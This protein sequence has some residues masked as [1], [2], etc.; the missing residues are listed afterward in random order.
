MYN[1]RIPKVI[2]NG[3]V[4]N[5]DAQS[6]A[7]VQYRNENNLIKLTDLPKRLDEVRID[8]DPIIKN[9][10][11]LSDLKIPIILP[12]SIFQLTYIPSQKAVDGINQYSNTD[13]VFVN[14]ALNLRLAGKLPVVS[15][16]ADKFYVEERFGELRAFNEFSKRLR[17]DEMESSSHD[18]SFFY[19]PSTKEV[20]HVPHRA[21][22][23]PKDLLLVKLS[24]PK[25][26]DP[27]GYA[28]SKGYDPGL[29]IMRG[30]G[31]TPHHLANIIPLEQTKLPEMLRN[32]ADRLTEYQAMDSGRNI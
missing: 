14:K 22:E 15:I 32:N 31:Y 18:L 6:E 25:I 1:H 24:T 30:A 9:H 2:L 28:V 21:T 10:D 19:R 13:Y 7:L 26:L 27:I 5:I 8:Y 17:F 4:F 3:T 11:S 29:L 12:K 16:G 20:Y 23:V